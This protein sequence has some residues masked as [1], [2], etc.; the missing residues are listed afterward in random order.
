MLTATV[1]P[2]TILAVTVAIAMTAG[3]AIAAA[4]TPK[5]PCPPNT[6]SKDCDR[7]AGGPALRKETPPPPS[8]TPAKPPTSADLSKIQAPA[9]QPSGGSPAAAAATATPPAL[10]VKKPAPPAKPSP[11]AA[12]QPVK[13]NPQVQSAQ[14]FMKAIQKDSAKK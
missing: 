11:D 13:P 5:P 2:R 3:A 1:A 4:Q 14:D 8:K 7:N 6:L 12:S 10:V 9:K